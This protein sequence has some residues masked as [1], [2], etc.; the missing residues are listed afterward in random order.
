MEC[1]ILLPGKNKKF[2]LRFYGPVNPI[3]SCRVWSVY[4]T[5]LLLNRLIPLWLTSIVHIFCQ[6]LTTTLLE[7]VDGRE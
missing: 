6:K 5:I 1:Q 7:S 4:L 2:V 3:E